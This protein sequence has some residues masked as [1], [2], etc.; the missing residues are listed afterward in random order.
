[1]EIQIMLIKTCKLFFIDPLRGV[2]SSIKEYT[3][4]LRVF[5]FDTLLCR[6]V[7]HVTEDQLLIEA[8][9]LFKFLI[10]C[11]LAN[12]AIN[13]AFFDLNSDLM[14]EITSESAYLVFFVLRFVLCYYLGWI[15]EKLT[16]S[17][18]HKVVAVR[19]WLMTTFVATVLF[20]L[21]G[22]MNP[23]QAAKAKIEEAIISDLAIMISAYAL[24]FLFQ[25]LRLYRARIVRWHDVIFYLAFYCIC[26]F[27][28]SIKSGLIQTLIS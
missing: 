12:L 19:L 11:I 4:F 3:R 23:G 18:A 13:E 25:F 10:F 22:I 24:L 15:Y 20:Q 7:L 5:L 28:L 16:G 8:F 17:S 6:D 14:N 27:L 26:I 9:K 2:W 1:M 21:T